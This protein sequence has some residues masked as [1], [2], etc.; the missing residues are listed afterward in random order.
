MQKARSLYVPG[1]RHGCGRILVPKRPLDDQVVILFSSCPCVAPRKHLGDRM[2][3][4]LLL[5]VIVFHL[6]GLYLRVWKR[7]LKP[8]E[9]QKSV[10]TADICVTDEWRSTSEVNC[11]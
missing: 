11:R 7:K 3:L 4:V 6:S 9:T 5:A 8:P 1:C 2:K 10:K